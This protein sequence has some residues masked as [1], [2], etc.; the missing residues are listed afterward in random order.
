[1]TPRE[2][3]VLRLIG[4]GRSNRE[5]ADDL[6]ISVRTVGNHVSNVI[7]KLGVRSSRAAV[8]EARRRGIL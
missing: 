6:F 3:D 8:A 1:L 4:R 7:A 5:V 2:L